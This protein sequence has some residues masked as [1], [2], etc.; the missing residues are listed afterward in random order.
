VWSSSRSSVADVL[1]G[2]SILVVEDD[3]LL[4]TELEA[5]LRDAGAENVHG[6]RTNREAMAALDDHAIA[7]AVLDVRIGDDTV[8]PVARKLAERGTPFFFYT[9]QIHG[10][11][12]ISAWQDRLVLA[13]PAHSGLI[14]QSVIDLLEQETT[15]RDVTIS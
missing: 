6:C 11:P 8:A 5:V 3:F 13:K 10:D 9:G 2:V 15:S 12:T 4:L 14:V 1:R 7:A